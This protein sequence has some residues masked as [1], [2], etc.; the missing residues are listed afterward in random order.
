VKNSVI[1]KTIVQ[2][3]SQVTNAN[4]RESMIGNEASYEGH[5]RTVSVGDY[6]QI[7]E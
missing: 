1:Q 2:Q 3:N 4:L 6:S 5:A 7:A